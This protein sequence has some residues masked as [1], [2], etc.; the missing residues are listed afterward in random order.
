VTVLKRLNDDFAVYGEILGL[1]E[2]EMG[3]GGEAGLVKQ[4]VELLIE[5]RA[6]ARKNKNFEEA[7][8][9]RDR[10]KAMGIVLEDSQ[11]GTTWKYDEDAN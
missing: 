5:N 8:R 4:L 9:I 6:E 7:D 2:Q 3:T 1:F 11:S 10:L